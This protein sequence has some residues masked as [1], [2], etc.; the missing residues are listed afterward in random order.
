MKKLKLIALIIALL[1]FPAS[2]NAQTPEQK[3]EKNCGK[4]EQTTTTAQKIKCYANYGIDHCNDYTLTEEFKNESKGKKDQELAAINK[5]YAD[6]TQ[7]CK[8]LS[9]QNSLTNDIQF[10]N[11]TIESCI[12]LDKAYQGQFGE[13]AGSNLNKEQV[14]LQKALD[15]NFIYQILEEPLGTEN[16]L[17]RQT[18]CTYNYL[19]DRNGFYQV[20][21]KSSNIKIGDP[22]YYQQEFTIVADTCFEFFVNKCSPKPLQSNRHKITDDFGDPTKLP[23]S[24]TCKTVQLIYGSSGTDFIKQYVGFIYRLASGIIGVIAVL[25]IVVSGIQISMAGDDS[26]KIGEAKER[27]VQ[28]LFGLAVLFLAGLILRSVNPNFFTDQDVT[29][30]VPQANEQTNSN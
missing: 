24:T 2:L 4:Y 13:C 3:A 19:R 10:E 23:T 5:K 25:V 22:G 30:N 18:T 7:T 15:N 12:K 20:A 17:K 29:I 6:L 14:E 11:K 1:I 27:I 21:D 16:L 28:S 8:Q 9:N 26:A